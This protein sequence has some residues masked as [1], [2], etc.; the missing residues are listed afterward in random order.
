MSDNKTRTEAI[1]QVSR[2]DQ[3]TVLL[4]N[5][6]YIEAVSSMRAALYAEFEDSKLDQPAVRHE[7]WQRMQLKQFH[8]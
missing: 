7:L 5:P 3:A 8:S 6:L 2:A 1:Q 4:V